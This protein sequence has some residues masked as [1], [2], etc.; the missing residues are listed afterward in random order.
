MNSI[1]ALLAASLAAV[2][3]SAQSTNQALTLV[4][5]VDGFLEIPYSAQLVPQSGMTFEAWITYDDST[6]G[7]G[8]RFPTL[9]RQNI[10][11][12]AEAYFIRIEAGNTNA[13]VLRFKVVTTGG[14]VAV[15][16]PFSPGQLSVWTHV[17]ATYDGQSAELFVNGVSVASAPGTGQPIT[18]RGGVLRIGKGDDSGGPIEVWNGN[19]DEVRLWPFARTAAEIA[20]SS[21][22][23]ISGLTGHVSTWNLD[24]AGTDSSANQHATAQGSVAYV[25]GAPL[26]VIPSPPGVLP[27]GASAAGCHGTIEQALTCLPQ[28]GNAAFGVAAHRVGGGVAGVALFGLPRATPLQVLGI[29]LYVE[30]TVSVGLT[31]TAG[32]LGAA[33][34]GLAI[35]SIATGASIASQFVF[36]DPCGPSGLTA[37][38]A[39]A[40][41]VIP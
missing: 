21:A 32:P 7:S 31:A 12:Q 16:W 11:P 37:S 25:A 23:G 34:V 29:S 27:T 17:A 2:S 36:L 22:Q 14:Q 1:P 33:R 28:S 26:T 13:L 10:T 9:C 4:N 18:D 41:F 15:A 5:G 19:I 40:I 30:P 35:P 24:G 6:I 8:W 20:A 38:N 3:L 39:L